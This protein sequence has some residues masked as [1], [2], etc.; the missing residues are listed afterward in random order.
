MSFPRIKRSWIIACVF[1]AATWIPIYIF[2]SLTY[3]LLCLLK[4]C[5]LRDIFKVNAVSD[6]FLVED[7]EGELDS[8]STIIFESSDYSK[9]LHKRIFNESLTMK[10]TYSTLILFCS[11]LW[12]QRRGQ[13][14][15]IQELRMQFTRSTLQIKPFSSIL[16][17]LINCRNSSYIKTGQND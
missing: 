15:L 17:S 11:Y 12:W 8:V 2:Q 9:L 5:Y 10:T 4:M 3:C 6:P 16:S 14:I 7:L 1:C 13:S